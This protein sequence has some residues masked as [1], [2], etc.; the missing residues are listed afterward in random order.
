[1]LFFVAAWMHFF[2]SFSLI[3]WI[4]K[5][6]RL[7]IPIRQLCNKL[8]RD[9][10]FSLWLPGGQGLIFLLFSFFFCSPA[11]V[12][13]L[14]PRAVF[15]DFSEDAAG[16]TVT[17]GEGC[18]MCVHAKTRKNDLCV[19]ISSINICYILMKGN[20]ETMVFRFGMDVSDNCS[21]HSSLFILY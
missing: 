12:K 1:M 9:S 11:A 21:F 15:V 16:E 10:Y 2:L 6:R 8:C 18:C 7:S 19:I 13:L 20:P 14:L 4:N 3:I 17:S 5:G